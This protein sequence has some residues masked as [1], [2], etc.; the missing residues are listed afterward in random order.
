MYKVNDIEERMRPFKMGVT[1]FAN[2][3]LIEEKVLRDFLEDKALYE[4]IDEYDL[5]SNGLLC[6]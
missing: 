3:T 5:I 2:T 6:I 4:D 1:E